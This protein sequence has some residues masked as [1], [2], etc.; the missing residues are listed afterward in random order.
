M[1]SLVQLSTILGFQIDLGCKKK[2]YLQKRNWIWFS[3]LFL[4]VNLIDVYIIYILDWWTELFEEIVF[5]LFCSRCFVFDDSVVIM[6][7][8]WVFFNTYGVSSIQCN[9]KTQRLFSIGQ[10]WRFF[11]FNVSFTW[12]FYF[13]SCYVHFFL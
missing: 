11:R 10:K 13:H 8:V 3:F 5:F 2:S 7:K 9:E 12:N 4:I 1:Y 6:L